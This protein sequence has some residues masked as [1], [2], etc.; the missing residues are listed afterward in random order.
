MKEGALHCCITTWPLHTC[1]FKDVNTSR[2]VHFENWIFYVVHETKID[3]CLHFYR[4]RNVLE[5]FFNSCSVTLDESQTSFLKHLKANL[6]LWPWFY[7]CISSGCGYCVL[8]SPL[9]F[10]SSCEAFCHFLLYKCCINNG[11]SLATA[12][13]LSC[14]T[15]LHWRILLH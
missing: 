8:C 6:F 4:T 3:L 13:L 1:G 5:R 11:Y 15:W 12:I 7:N 9:S 10:S 2:I 14:S